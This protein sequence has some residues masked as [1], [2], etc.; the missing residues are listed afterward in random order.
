M[1]NKWFEDEGPVMHRAA[2]L[3]QSLS[4]NSFKKQT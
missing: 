4:Y 1:L 3:Q 2:H